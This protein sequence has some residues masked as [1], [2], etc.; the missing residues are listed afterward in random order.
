LGDRS[1]PGEFLLQV[2]HTSEFEPATLSKACALLYVVF[3]DMTEGDWEHC[4]GGVH[5]MVWHDDA[6]VGHASV[7]Q[8]RLVHRGRALRTGYIEGV[9]VHPDWK[10]KG[11]G[12]AVMDPLERVIAAAYDIGALGASDEAATFYEHRHWV[13]WCGRTFA[14]TPDGV[15]RTAD[16]DDSI[17]VLRVPS[18]L[19]DL[20]LDVTGDLM[21][22][23]RDGDVW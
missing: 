15:V 10:G 6:V 9:G 21:C 13:K 1:Q 7:V 20:P 8:R 19:A 5:A 14:M 3:D 2:G 16:E 12:A 4:I 11:L 22:D 23:W 18:L 17:Y